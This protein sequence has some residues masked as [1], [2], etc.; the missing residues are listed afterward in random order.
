MLEFAYN[1]GEED[2]REASIICSLSLTL[3]AIFLQID[4]AQF[5]TV[6]VTPFFTTHGV[7]FIFHHDRLNN[8]IIR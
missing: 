4:I 5:I 8:L 3:R 6:V 7:I 1:N 2:M